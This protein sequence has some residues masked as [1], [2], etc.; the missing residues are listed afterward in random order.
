MI[1]CPELEEEEVAHGLPFINAL[2]VLRGTSTTVHI[3]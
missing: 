3:H 2:N 1:V